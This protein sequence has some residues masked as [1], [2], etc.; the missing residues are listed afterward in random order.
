MFKPKRVIILTLVIMFMAFSCSGP[1][2]D[3]PLL[4]AE[5]P[6]HLE[7]HLEAASIEGSEVPEDILAPVEWRFDEPQSEWKPVVPL[8][9]RWKP[10]R[11][12]HTVDSIR[13]TL[14]KANLRY[15]GGIY[16]SV[17]DWKREDWAYV[18]VRARTTDNV[19]FLNIAYNLGEKSGPLGQIS[20][21]G[22]EMDVIKDG[23]VQT[24]MLRVDKMYRRL[25]DPWRNLVIW[26]NTFDDVKDP[27]S[28]D[29]LSVSV[30]P[31]E[32]IYAAEP[33]GVKTEFRGIAYRRALYTHAPSRLKYRV[34]V[35]KR[36][37][38]DFGLGVARNDPPVTFKVSVELKSGEVIILFDETFRDN[39]RWS[40]RSIDLSEMAG[41]IVTLIL[42]NES[43]RT[44]SVAL[45]TAPTL[46]GEKT[47]DKPNVIFYVIDGGGADHMSVYGYNRR[48]TPNLERLA[49]EGAVFE[50]AYSNCTFTKASNPSFMT[51]LYN[52]VL[53]GYR[54][55]SD[56]LP[57]QA[58]PMAEHFHGAGYQTAIFASNPYC[59]TLSSLDR[60]VDTLR[61]AEYSASS[62]EL[63]SDFWMWRENY[64]AEPFWVHFQT[65]D[66]H[67]PLDTEP[68]FAGLFINADRR[69]TYWDRQLRSS[70]SRQKLLEAKRDLY[71]EAMAHND[72]QIGRMVER[73]KATGEWDHTLFIVAADHGHQAAGLHDLLSPDIRWTWP[74]RGPLFHPILT[75]IP[76]IV[77]WPERI[78]P[79]QSFSHPVSMIDILPTIL[80]L[81]DLSAPEIIQG[82]SLAPLLL[83]KKGWEPR[84]VILDEFFFDSRTGGLS[85]H[86][87]VIDGRWGASLEID[88]GRQTGNK[89][90]FGKVLSSPQRQAPVI[91]YDL[92]NDPHCLH[93][94]HEER[95]DLIKK[96][97]RF[98]QAKWKEHREL[99]KRFTRSEQINLTAE[100]LRSLRS[101]GYIR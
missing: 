58:V 27:V 81:C 37:R 19:R 79:G 33:V 59:G 61:D 39:S 96:Y 28:I 55:D 86:I 34:R 53:G 83:G 90:F 16:V 101:L 9:P 51:S 3:Q 88:H 63:Q 57:D 91:L 68:P 82:Q 84:P 26:F 35:P 2:S 93:S 69:E 80:E 5:V 41:K 98:L 97:T 73:L 43:E 72:Y 44:G 54:T 38:I 60:G 66:V 78:A 8:D 15:G 47:T 46:S 87:D 50:H 76:L 92:W 45:W 12:E 100:Q 1:E 14:T 24:Y 42:E 21:Y 74:V 64:P 25:E 52:S 56:P 95:P 85:G 10:V 29:I 20:Y 67:V 11:I 13:L 70:F 40:Q 99:A 75:R 7:E 36:G 30:I 62:K 49:A 23:S 6:L 48:T 31:K 4:T 32:A 94:L 18:Q 89:P 71:D 77:V 17:P 22:D 65:M